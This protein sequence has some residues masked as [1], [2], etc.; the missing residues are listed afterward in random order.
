M[1]KIGSKEDESPGPTEPFQP[2]RTSG[3]LMSQNLGAVIS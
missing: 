2:E 3:N 1:K